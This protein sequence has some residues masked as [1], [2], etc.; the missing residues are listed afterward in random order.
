MVKQNDPDWNDP[1]LSRWLDPMTK[2]GTKALYRTAFRT[3]AKFTNMTA[4]TL[5]DE[6]LEDFKRDP[7]QKQDVVLK[8]LI[9]FFQWLKTDYERKTRGVGEHKVSGKGISDKLAHVL[10]NAIR[11]FYATYGV[12]VRLKGRYALPKAKRQ[13]KRMIVDSTQV[14]TLVD[15]SRNLRDKAMIL[16]M[17]QSGLDVSTLCNLTFGDVSEGLAKN[18]H[19]LKLDLLRQKSGTEFFTFI[20]KDAIEALKVCI[21]DMKARGV[22]F[23]KDTALFLKERG[24]EQLT[25]NLVQNMMQEVAL[26][27]GL[28]D[29]GNNGNFFNP[30]GPHALRESFGSIMINSG[31]PD[32]IVDFWLGHSIG[33][34]SEAYKSIQFESVKRMYLEREQLLSITRPSLDEKGLAEKVEAKVDERIQTLQKI[35]TNLSTENLDLKTRMTELE[36]E[37]KDWFNETEKLVKLFDLILN[38]EWDKVRP[39]KEQLKMIKAREAEEKAKIESQLRR[40]EGF[41]D[42]ANEEAEKIRAER[43]SKV[44]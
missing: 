13:N 26:R 1:A 38:N 14:R 9:S 44:E 27:S 5:I 39:L 36:R 22:Q 12:T 30:L 32:T 8:R 35:L 6:A 4:S 10:V 19:P 28:V 11:S 24:K 15:N 43:K 37:S 17:F 31:V 25:P 29:K 23:T 40:K 41:F 42:K 33:E 2:Y 7:R 3:Y 21:A 34:M 16:T 20:G 18:E